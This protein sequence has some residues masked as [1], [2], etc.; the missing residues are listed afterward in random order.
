MTASDRLIA[1]VIAV[2]WTN[3]LGQQIDSF[4]V[5]ALPI[6]NSAFI[7]G[8]VSIDFLRRYKAVIDIEQ[9]QILVIVL[10]DN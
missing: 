6:P 5:I 10:R 2:P 3:C 7:D 9:A 1:P 4:P 8:L